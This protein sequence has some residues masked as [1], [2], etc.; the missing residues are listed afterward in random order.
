MVGKWHMGKAPDKIPAARGFERDF[1]LFDG[2]GSYWD[3]WNLTAATPRSTYTED[4][5]YLTELPEDYYATKTYTNK[6]IGFID[7]NSTKGFWRRVASGT[8]SS[9]ADP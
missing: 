7:A 2:A 9:S 1:S 8:G 5:R 4:G 6:L 3:M